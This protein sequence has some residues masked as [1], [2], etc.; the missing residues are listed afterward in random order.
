MSQTILGY[1]YIPRVL[2]TRKS[3]VETLSNILGLKTPHNSIGSNFLAFLI[4]LSKLSDEL[5]WLWFRFCTSAPEGAGEGC[6][7][8]TFI[9]GSNNNFESLGIVNI[10]PDGKGF[11]KFKIGWWA[12]GTEIK[13]CFLTSFISKLFFFFEIAQLQFVLNDSVV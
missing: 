6:S 9:S 8:L 2:S 1:D 11:P 5:L 10:G 13:R 4:N 3:Q 7:I 12:S